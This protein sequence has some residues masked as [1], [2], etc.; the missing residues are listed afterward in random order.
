MKK[1]WNFGDTTPRTAMKYAEPLPPVHPGM[2]VWSGASDL[3]SHAYRFA[4]HCPRA[5]AYANLGKAS[6]PQSDRSGLVVSVADDGVVQGP[7][8]GARVEKLISAKSSVYMTRGTLIHTALAHELIEQSFAGGEAVVICG[9]LYE[10]PPSNVLF[11]SAAEA[12][13]C[14]A[15]LSG[16]T[17]YTY[18]LPA[19]R[20]MLP[21][22]KPWVSELLQREQV[23]TIETQLYW[24]V[25]APLPYTARLDLVTRNRVSGLY[26]GWDYKTAA[27]P[28]SAL[29]KYTES[30]QL[31]GQDILGGKWAGAA[32]NGVQIL[33][34][35]DQGDQ[36]GSSGPGSMTQWPL[37]R[38]GRAGRWF[39]YAVKSAQ[40]R[41]APFL[42]K[43]VSA[44]PCNPF[45][46]S[47]CPYNA[48]CEKS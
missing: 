5:F 26:R 37:P 47:A 6:L 13:E 9:K 1:S 14:A 12:V 8:T 11:Y 17:A 30:A 36:A 4:V 31:H 32:W 16:N 25:D 24:H 43:P 23:V 41:V 42:G 39:E 22:I 38:S 28:K 35:E 18:A 40:D 34:V 44:W 2:L 29:A 21:Q 45:Y 15:V 7:F 20:R 33:L 48:V 3:G 46:C 10:A 19:A 27:N